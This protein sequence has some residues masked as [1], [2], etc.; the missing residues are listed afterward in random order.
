MKPSRNAIG[1]RVSDIPWYPHHIPC[2]VANNIVTACSPSY[3]PALE[4]CLVFA[5]RRASGGLVDRIPLERARRLL[6]EAST[7]VLAVVPVIGLESRAGGLILLELTGRVVGR[8]AAVHRGRR[9]GS[10]TAELDVARRRRV[11]RRDTELALGGRHPAGTVEG[12][13]AATAAAASGDSQRGGG[14][15]NQDNDD[16]ENDP[17][18]PAVP[19][20]AIPVVIVVESVTIVTL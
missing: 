15:E 5:G 12:L 7:V 20:T 13:A 19:A 8:R 18:T 2:L 9:S 3:L 10:D 6:H 14:E 16:S 4:G 11:R 1:C 17:A